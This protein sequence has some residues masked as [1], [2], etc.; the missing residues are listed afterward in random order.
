MYGSTNSWKVYN[1][2]NYTHGSGYTN[3]SLTVTVSNIQSPKN[4]KIATINKHLFLR[5]TVTLTAHNMHYY[6]DYLPSKN[7]TAIGN[8]NNLYNLLV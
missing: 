2:E 1:S 8:V 5:Y 7:I 6:V 4:E 3:D